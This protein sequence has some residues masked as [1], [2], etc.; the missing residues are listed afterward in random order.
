[1]LDLSLLEK[2]KVI[3][4]HKN[5]HDGMA[6]AM[7]LRD[8]FAMLNKC[9]EIVF[10]M[11][12]TPE[13]ESAGLDLCEDPSCEVALFCDITPS[14]T[15]MKMYGARKNFIVLDHHS[16]QEDIV[17]AFGERGVYADAKKEPGVSGATLAFREVWEP[18]NRTT[19]T[20]DFLFSNRVNQ[21]RAFAQ[22]VGARD[23][24]QKQS[25]R[26][27]CGSWTAQ[28]LMSKP[29]SYWLS[30]RTSDEFGDDSQPEPFL[31]A[32][33]VSQG[34]LLYELH[35]EA[36]RKTVKQT[37]FYEIKDPKKG[38][39][40]LFV[41]QERTSGFHL[42]SDVAEELRQPSPMSPQKQAVVAGFSYVVD[43]PGDE[44]VLVY[45]LRGINSYDVG[46][47]AVC[48]GGGGHDLAAGFSVPIRKAGAIVY[49]DPYETIRERVERFLITGD[50]WATPYKETT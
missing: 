7:I 1:M 9:P 45:S 19:G 16:K 34:K 24:W 46:A 29:P 31:Y 6:S 12:N 39:V 44:P 20:Y 50:G 48:N 40:E 26:F 27:P 4:T 36:V 22:D 17:K 2:V 18:I 15:F 21:V 32:H 10:L 25:P 47:L 41:F 33:E 30:P 49:Q 8:A 5:C 43:R 13:Y 35:M 14:R 42:T 38:A 28:M 11:Y 23:T 3:Y 37:K